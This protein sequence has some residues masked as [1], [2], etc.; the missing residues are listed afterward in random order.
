MS[1][2]DVVM[3]YRRKLESLTPHNKRIWELA[4]SMMRAMLRSE[5]A[6]ARDHWKSCEKYY[7]ESKKAESELLE[8]LTGAP[9][10][11]RKP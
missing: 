2:G 4:H 10:A 3:E 5:D 1:V 8:L 7:D 11:E 6:A 9:P